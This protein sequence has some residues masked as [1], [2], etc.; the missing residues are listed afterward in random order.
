MVKRVIEYEEIL[1]EEVGESFFKELE[2][3]AQDNPLLLS[4][5]KNGKLKSKQ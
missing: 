1:K 2:K 3:F 4:Y 5:A